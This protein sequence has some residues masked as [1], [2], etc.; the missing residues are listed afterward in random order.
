MITTSIVENVKQIAA[1][2]FSIKI[3]EIT[4]RSSTDSIETWDSLQHLVFV[5]ALEQYYSLQFEPEEI[6]QMKSIEIT[7]MTIEE[8]LLSKGIEP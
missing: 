5:L 3:E 8:K 7:I 6:E 2:V 4:M 1:D